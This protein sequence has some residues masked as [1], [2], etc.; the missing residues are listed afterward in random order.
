MC[1]TVFLPF[2]NRN[3]TCMFT[4]GMRLNYIGRKKL[5]VLVS[6]TT[7][8]HSTLGL[9]KGAELQ[10]VATLLIIGKNCVTEV[11]CELEYIMKNNLISLYCNHLSHQRDLR[12][13]T[14]WDVLF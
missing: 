4:S 9:Q 13:V 1:E 10:T 5:R 2:P 14:R 8:V 7:D 12:H 11:E 3:S 6:G